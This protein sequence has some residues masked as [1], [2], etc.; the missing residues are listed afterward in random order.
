M[1]IGTWNLE[2]RT[3]DQPAQQ[4]LL[5]DLDCDVLLLTEIRAPFELPGYEVHLGGAQMMPHRRWAGVASRGTLLPLPDP[6][7][8]SAMAAAH[9]V[10]FCSSILPW[11]GTAH[12]DFWVGETHEEWTEACVSALLGPMRHAERL[13]WGGDWNHAMAGPEHAGS[14][15]GRE[16]ILAAVDALELEVATTDL[17]HRVEGLL[18]IDHVAVHQH[19]RVFDARRVV[20]VGADD[21]PLSDHDAY[22]LDVDLADV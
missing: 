5:L 4:Q 18:S 8:A 9:G 21:R 2:G 14:M 1:R 22:V 7:P 15:A 6:H 10:T 11:K 19:S 3:I 16:H 17:P 13:V 20:A 12:R